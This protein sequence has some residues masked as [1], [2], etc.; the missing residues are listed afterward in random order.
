[1]YFS[2]KSSSSQPKSLKSVISAKKIYQAMKK[3]ANFKI[4][5]QYVNNTIIFFLKLAYVCICMYI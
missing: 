2:Q 3:S 1:M 4:V 5:L